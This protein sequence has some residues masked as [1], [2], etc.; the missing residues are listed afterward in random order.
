MVEICGKKT[1]L[2]EKARQIFEILKTAWPISKWLFCEHLQTPNL[3]CH[4]S[5]SIDY[6]RWY[7][8]LCMIHN[9]KPWLFSFFCLANLC[10]SYGQCFR[11]LRHSN[12]PIH[13]WM[14]VKGSVF[15]LKLSI[16]QAKSI[17]TLRTL[18]LIDFWAAYAVLDE[19]KK[20]NKRNA[21]A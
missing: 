17:V 1:K 13:C 20:K 21:A 16:S 7:S 4:L 10:Y 6:F 2:K 14:H 18:I 11:F 19:V 12:V 3:Y 8:M 9:T 5:V 15:C